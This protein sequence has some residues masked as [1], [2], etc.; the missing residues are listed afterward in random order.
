MNHSP[1]RML[2]VVPD[3]FVGGAER[4]LV[5]LLTRIDPDRFDP[6]V[7]CI[8]DEGPF[9][10]ELVAAG[11]P[12]RA[13]HL[14]K[15]DAL[16]ALGELVSAM[17]AQNTDVVVVRGYSAEALGRLAARIAGVPHSIVWAHN[18]GDIKPRG[19]IRTVADRL[20]DRWTTAYFGVAEAQRSY[21][22]DELH[23]PD[24]KIRIL[25]NGIATAQFEIPADHRVRAELGIA[26]DAPVAGIVAALRPE[27]DHATFL[28]AARIVVD[29]MPQAKFLVVG[30]GP[31]R[32]QV[33]TLCAKLNLSSSVVFTGSRKDVDR[34]LSAMDVFVLSSRTVEC[35]PIAVLE[36]MAAGLPTVS[37]DVGGVHEMLIDGV[38]GFLVPHSDPRQLANRILQLFSDPD[39]AR[40]MG[41]AAR[42]KVKSEFDLRRTVPAAEE[43]IEEAIGAK[44]AGEKRVSR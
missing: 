23:Y 3:L 30:E 43:A 12:A 1:I 29:A 37:T 10:T 36:A 17:R 21:L 31:M 38:T 41:R 27:K 8:G 9:F 6:L 22:V 40:R 20:L 19:M 16:S 13:L 42:S 25:Q 7:I 32:V 4:H 26:A 18:I 28:R 24:E 5:T 44:V 11:I 15:R 2:F 39:L 35:F 33:E 14:R 34:I